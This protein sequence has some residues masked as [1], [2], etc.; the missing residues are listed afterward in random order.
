MRQRKM[1][2]EPAWHWATRRKADARSTRPEWISL[3]AGQQQLCSGRRILARRASCW[4]PLLGPTRSS[5]P[6]TWASDGARDMCGS[7][8][9]PASSSFAQVGAESP[10]GPRGRAPPL[11]LAMAHGM[12]IY[13]R[14]RVG[15]APEIQ[16]RCRGPA[17]MAWELEGS[18]GERRCLAIGAE[19]EWCG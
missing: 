11:G 10:S 18:S 8:S 7:A 12:Q 14:W 6:Q 19:E 16:R 2:R 17:A 13:S 3:T 15:E 5:P 1:R 4:G 9:P